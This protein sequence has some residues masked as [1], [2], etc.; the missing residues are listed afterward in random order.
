MSVRVAAHPCAITHTLSQIPPF[1]TLAPV[2]LEALARQ[3]A[4][5]TYQRGAPVALAPESIYVVATGGVRLYRLDGGGHALTLRLLHAGEAFTVLPDTHAQVCTAAT[6]LYVLLR[7]A[8]QGLR[9]T[10][11]AFAEATVQLLQQRLADA[12][13]RME[14][15]ALGSIATRLAR[16]LAR[17]AQAHPEQRVLLSH[18]ELAELLGTRPEQITKMLRVFRA[19]DWVVTQPTQPGLVVRD[20]ATLLAL[21][22]EAG[23][24]LPGAACAGSPPASRRPGAVLLAGP[25]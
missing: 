25:A 2:A 8:L 6:R 14:D 23:A 18:Q 9:E 16:V 3:A 22:E 19:R 15:L 5:Q 24:A 1:Q 7:S 21:A 17:L 11:P 20:P 4:V 13:A 12:Y 10:Q